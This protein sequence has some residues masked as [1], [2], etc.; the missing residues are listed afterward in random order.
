M[1]GVH[2]FPGRHPSDA[3]KAFHGWSCFVYGDTG[4][5]V[6][7]FKK[8]QTITINILSSAQGK[9]HHGCCIHYC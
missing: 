5:E 2:D 6:H 4:K 7:E 1:A 3:A 9:L 8:L